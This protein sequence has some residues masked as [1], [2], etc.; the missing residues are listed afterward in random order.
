LLLTT[1]QA[2][3]MVSGAV[4]VSSQTTSVRAANLLA[5]FI[6]IPMA[7]LVQG[8]SMVMFWA[9][10]SALWWAI[11]GLVVIAILLVRTGLAY[12]NREELLGREMDTLNLRWGWRVFKKAFV[13]QAS[14]VWQWYRVEIPQALRE[15]RLPAVFMTL[16]LTI[17]IWAGISQA[18]AF[19]LPAQALDLDS[20]GQSLIHNLASLD[21]MSAAGVGTVWFHNLRAVALAT[22]LGVFSFG[23]IGVLVLMI[24]LTLIAYLTANIAAAGFSPFTFLLA[25]VLPH[26][27]FEIPAIILSGAAILSLGAT[28]ATPAKGKTIG[29]AGLNALARWTKIMLG[30]VAPLFLAAAIIEAL[31]TPLVA[32]AVLGK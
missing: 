24:P 27:V 2:I 11:I 21:F 31:V 10:Y 7:M 19:P 13:G 3:V 9:I 23:V 30:V 16:M 1:V 5:S 26:S 22:L 12:F 6:I 28:L 18:S 15:M 32:A 17:G 4:V 14:S 8:E 29:E 25:L 20:L